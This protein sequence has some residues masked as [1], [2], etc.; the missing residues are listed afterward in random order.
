ML[1]ATR[2]IR[3]GQ[4]LFVNYGHNFVL[5]DGSTHRTR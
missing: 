5:N 3:E 2:N 4:E 1:R